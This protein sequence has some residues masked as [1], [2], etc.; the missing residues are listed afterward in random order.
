MKN[1]MKNKENADVKVAFVKVGLVML[2]NGDIGVER[3]F[4]IEGHFGF[5]N[6][7]MEP[8]DEWLPENYDGFKHSQNYQGKKHDSL[9]GVQITAMAPFLD[10]VVELAS[11]WPE[12]Q[13][14]AL[15]NHF[16]ALVA[17]YC[18]TKAVQAAAG[19][20]GGNPIESRK[21]FF[22]VRNSNT[23]VMNLIGWEKRQSQEEKQ[24]EKN[25]TIVEM[26]RKH[27]QGKDCSQET[28]EL[29]LKMGGYAGTAPQYVPLTA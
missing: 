5:F 28:W 15:K 13:K 11:D 9:G 16:Q 23:L 22:W 4:E 10:K 1:G 29:I 6:E 18:A 25:S 12:E 21:G 26:A 7:K 17:H 8:I 2:P 14:Q 24:E 3:L 27:L 20:K 19:D